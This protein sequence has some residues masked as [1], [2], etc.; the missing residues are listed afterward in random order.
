LSCQGVHGTY[1]HGVSP[2]YQLLRIPAVARI[3]D[4]HERTVERYVEEGKLAVVRFG[5]NVRVRPEELERFIQ[6]SEDAAS[7]PKAA[8]TSR[9]RP[10]RSRPQGAVRPKAGG[11]RV[12]KRRA[13][14][15]GQSVANRLT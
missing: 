6:S 12:I 15:P 7:R 5:G 4:V 8:P 10:S 3:L 11:S 14:A 13:I 2:D 1:V 9:K